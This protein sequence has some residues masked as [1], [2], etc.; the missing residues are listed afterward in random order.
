MNKLINTLLIALALLLSQTA[1]ALHDI[2]CL[3][4]DHS[5]SC[6]VCATHDHNACDIVSQNSLQA[7]TFS[8]Q[9]EIAF[10]VIP[11]DC[12]YSSYLSR[13]PPLDS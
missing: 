4:E 12:T 9:L 3:D 6:Q 11:T 5:Q 7:N 2:H 1:V 8:E 13:A 10:V